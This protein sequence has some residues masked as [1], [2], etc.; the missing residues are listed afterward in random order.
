MFS[1]RFHRPVTKTQHAARRMDERSIS[2][3]LLLDVIETGHMKSKDAT[4]VW[5]FKSIPGRPDN[6]IC[7]AVSP[8]KTVVVKTVLHYF[9]ESTP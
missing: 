6:A 5:L 2:E 9:Q 1:H 8:E 4:R 3:S 7:A